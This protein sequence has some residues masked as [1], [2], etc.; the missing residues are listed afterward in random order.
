M[1]GIPLAQ[2]A[3]LPQLH[4]VNPNSGA[5]SYLRLRLLFWSLGI[6]LA[7]FQT[8]NSRH[9]ATTDGVSYMD[10]SD[11]VLRGQDWHR[12]ITGVWSPL[13]PAILGVFRR[14]F[15]P[16]PAREMTFDHLVNIPIFLLA[17]A[18]FEFLL[19]SLTR[20]FFSAEAG[21]R[22]RVPRWAFL[23][24]AYSVFLWPSISAI[25]LLSVRRDKRMPA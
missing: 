6:V 12:L 2:S 5:S 15:A 1:E 3:S 23:T 13:Y 8:W 24:L 11:G 16:G 21:N 25:T 17:F 20:E 7:T 4:S 9:Y 18:S 19:S 14:I 10:M 22:P